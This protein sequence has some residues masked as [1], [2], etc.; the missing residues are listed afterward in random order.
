VAAKKSLRAALRGL[1]VFLRRG[2]PIQCLLSAPFDWASAIETAQRDSGPFD[3]TIVILSRLHPWVIPSLRGRAILD[4]VDSLRKS[5]AE[6]VRAATPATRWLWKREER[7]MKVLESEASRAYD[8]V[9][10]VSEEETSE[11]A[12]AVAVPLGIATGPLPSGERAC[13]FGFWGR[14]RYFANDD[15]ARWLLDEIWPA[16]QRLQPASTLVIGG[17]EASRSLRKLAERHGVNLVSPVDDMHD[18]ARTIRVALMPLRFGSGQATKVLEAA[19]AGCAIVATPHAVRGFEPLA[20]HVPIE[21]TAAA[22]AR[23]AVDLITDSPRRAR[24]ASALRDVVASD[25]S[26]SATLAR[27]SAI[28]SGKQ[29]A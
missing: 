11:F 4:A 25:Y 7:R 6:R 29:A 20:R 17:A 5:A 22:L 18:F 10:V 21:T 8:E 26:R 28:A 27:L 13:D 24:L 23:A 3:A 19:E 14:L 2:L 9:I 16:I 12:R 1:M 15:A